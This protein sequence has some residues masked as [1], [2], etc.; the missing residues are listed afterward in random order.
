[1]SKKWN[2][3]M[4]SEFVNATYPEF[5]VRGEVN[6]SPIAKLNSGLFLSNSVFLRA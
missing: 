5:E 4:F 1:M 3:E 6:C 2:T